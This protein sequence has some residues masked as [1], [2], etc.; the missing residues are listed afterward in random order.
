M[1][2]FNFK[3]FLF[4]SLAL[5]GLWAGGRVYQ[6]CTDQVGPQITV[7]GFNAER[8]CTGE[9]TCQI[10]CVDD[11]GVAD[12]TVWLD[13]QI[14]LTQRPFTSRKTL[15]C[16]VPLNTT[17]I[18][19]G[20][21]TLKVI[22][23]D[24]A[25]RA[26]TVSQ[27]FDF[28][29]DNQPL[30]ATLIKPL[31]TPA[32][33]QGRVLHLQLQSNKPL[34]DARGQALSST[35]QFAPVRP[36][37]LLY[38]AFIPVSCEELVGEYPFAVQVQDYVQKTV[39]LHG[40]FQVGAANFKKQQLTVS[41]AHLAA[42]QQFGQPQADLEAELVRLTAA[43]PVQK[44]WHGP[45]M[46]PLASDRITCEFG[47]AR[48]TVERG[49]Y[50]HQA[51]DLVDQPRSTVWAPQSGQVVLMG[52]YAATGN[53]VVIDHGLGLLTL[54]CHLDEFAN[55]V[56]GARIKQGNPVGTL[57]KTGYATGYHLHW[58]MRLNGVPVDPWQWL[59]LDF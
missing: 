58:E 46:L 26:N 47:V 48:T 22:A 57:G 35:A 5:I 30:E 55:L 23:R 1:R 33:L 4:L 43:S 25:Y 8:Y 40:K 32:V 44:N 12:L 56:V 29:V 20:V 24:G 3:N 17:T 31:H 19:D 18:T 13:Q 27:Q 50:R 38:E 51:I 9:I 53:T 54:L 52:R 34:K 7:T 36:G 16:T 59:K 15:S 21:H 41:P 28:H 14:V 11:Y 39:T 45:F 37:A 42:E 2:Y 10:Q 6:Y 49:W